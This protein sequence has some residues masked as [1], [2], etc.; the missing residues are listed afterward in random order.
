LKYLLDT[1]VVSQYAKPRRDP[2]VDAWLDRMDDRDL[3][4]S[5]FTMAE[6]HYGIEKL[7][8]GKRRAALEQWLEDDVYDQFF[9]RVEFFGLD[10][11]R[12]YAMLMAKAEESGHHPGVLDTLI[13]AT[14]QANGMIVATLNTKDFRR[15]GVEVVEF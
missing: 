11:A 2:R 10:V 7:P 4:I 6:L 1:D 8:P 15:L 12:R 5:V 13:G 9:N 3:H 14:A